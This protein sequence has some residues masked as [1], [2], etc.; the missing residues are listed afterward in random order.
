MQQETMEL[1]KDNGFKEQELRMELP[2][3]N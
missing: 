2:M 3:A 1:L